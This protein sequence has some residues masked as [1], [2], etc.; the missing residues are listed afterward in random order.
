MEDVWG[1]VAGTFTVDCSMAGV[2]VYHDMT[3]M[4]VYVYILMRYILMYTY[5]WIVL[6]LLS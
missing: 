2:I 5:T 4:Y 6:C 1:T 3:H